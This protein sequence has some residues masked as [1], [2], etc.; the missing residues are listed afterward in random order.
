M[1][2]FLRKIAACPGVLS[3]EE[4]PVR[5][6]E[7]ERIGHGPAQNGILELFA[8]NVENEGLHAGRPR[9]FDL[10]ELYAPRLARRKIVPGRPDKGRILAAD[11]VAVRFE[12]LE[13]HRLVAIIVVAD[14][15]EI[16]LADIDRQVCTPPVLHPVD[17]DVA[18]RFEGADA[19]GS[20]AQ[21][22]FQRGLG[23]I[24]R[25]PPFFRHHRQLTGDVGKLAVRRTGELELHLVR[26]QFHGA[27]DILVIE[28]V[29][30]RAVLL[31]GLER[32][33]HVVGG[34]GGAVVKPGFGPQREGGVGKIFRHLD[35]FRDQP[36]PGGNFVHRRRHQGLVYLA[37][38]GRGVALDDIGIERIERADGE[39]PQRAA[40]RRVR[41]HVI[42]V[43]ETGGVFQLVQQG[44][45]VA[46]LYAGFALR[47]GGRGGGADGKCQTGADQRRG[48]DFHG[49]WSLLRSSSL[50]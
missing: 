34:D 3:V 20:T 17:L 15:V 45:A 16:V 36:V 18:S 28:A 39:T 5:P 44:Q 9:M 10:L 33:D 29:K 7:I 31:E 24:A 49:L 2:R 46:D 12:G 30:R 50:M 8:A 11:V 1:R 42:K 21:G 27:R 32:P 6:L 19:V 43:P 37:D 38:A 48:Q 47:C 41:V 25:R 35:R 13:R 23:E 40:L 22:A 4:V 14:A 26:P